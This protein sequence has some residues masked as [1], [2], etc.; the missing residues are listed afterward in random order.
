MLVEDDPSI[1]LL[2]RDMLSVFGVEKIV[3]VSDG[4]KAFPELRQFPADIVITNWV[5]EP[6]DGLEFTRIVRNQPDSPNPFVP[7]IMLT[8]QGA[9]DRVQ[10]AHDNG[11][12][13]F[14]VKPLTAQAL[15]TRI[16]NV[17]QKPRQFV[18]APEYFGPD[19]RCTIKGFFR[20]EERRAEAEDDENEVS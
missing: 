1:R 9:F 15:Y 13:E 2:L 16:A 4:T 6:L 5:M 18:R 19:R 11:V 7:I 20:G 10:E 17:I 12:T 14:L 8:S 3:T